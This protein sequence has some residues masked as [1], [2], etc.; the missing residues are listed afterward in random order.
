MFSGFYSVI[1]TSRTI[2]VGTQ[3]YI[4]RI[5]VITGSCTRTYNTPNITARKLHGFSVGIEI[6]FVVV[7]VVEVDVVSMWGIGVDLISA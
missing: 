4:V 7:W 1:W 5:A 6:D 2:R 3:I